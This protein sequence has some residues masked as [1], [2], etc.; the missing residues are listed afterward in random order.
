MA[1]TNYRP[2]LLQ[3]STT[4]RRGKS[5]PRFLMGAAYLTVTKGFNE[6]FD[7]I[8]I[9]VEHST[10]SGAFHTKHE[11]ETALINITF[12]DGSI[13][14][15]TFA[16]LQHKLQFLAPHIDGFTTYT[17]AEFDETDD[18]FTDLPTKAS[19]FFVSN[20]SKLSIAFLVNGM[21]YTEFI[22]KRITGSFQECKDFL[23]E[24]SGE[25]M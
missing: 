24:E 12:A 6:S 3:V 10:G 20:Q 22:D 16:E 21:F 9:E 5:S 7:Q 23:S 13:W 25:T 18:Y 2:D 4:S 8:A 14:S 1:K 11:R 17:P 15:G 19:Y